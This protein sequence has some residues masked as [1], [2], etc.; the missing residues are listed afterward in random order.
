MHVTFSL[1]SCCGGS[2]TF[3]SLSIFLRRF[4]SYK[5]SKNIVSEMEFLGVELWDIIVKFST[6]HSRNYS[7]FESEVA[8]RTASPTTFHSPSSVRSQDGGNQLLL[9]DLGMMDGGQNSILGKF[10]QSPLFAFL[11]GRYN[12]VWDHMAQ[13]E[14]QEEI[15]SATKM[16]GS[17]YTAPPPP[18]SNSSTTANL[19][20]IQSITG[21]LPISINP[22]LCEV[23]SKSSTMI[24][25]NTEKKVMDESS[26]DIIFTTTYQVQ[27]VSFQSGGAFKP[28]LLNAL[29]KHSVIP[30]KWWMADLLLHIEE[31]SP[32]SSVSPLSVI[33]RL[34]KVK[35]MF[36]PATLVLCTSSPATADKIVG[37]VIHLEEHLDASTTT[38]AISSLAKMVCK[39]FQGVFVAGALLPSPTTGSN[40]SGVDRDTPLVDVASRATQYAN[41]E[42]Y[43]YIAQLQ[44][45]IKAG[46]SIKGA[47]ATASPSMQTPFAS[48]SASEADVTAAVSTGPN[49]ADIGLLYRDPEKALQNVDLQDA[50]EFTLQEF[51]NKMTEKF[52]KRV[53]K[54]GDPDYVY[55][56]RV[57]IKAEKASEW[58]DSDEE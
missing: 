36:D 31:S 34:C 9:H 8:R 2:C 49:K 55:D 48:A 16:V 20:A 47:G 40:S 45:I 4:G 14:M 35:M 15:E 5:F 54:P 25:T 10:V 26:G 30:K 43:K 33:P 13:D 1:L 56:K 12:H 28:V 57:E 6:K 3:L 39:S 58:D 32:S 23:V 53:V 18:S 46:G 11:C 21:M 41:T 17:F 24:V 42:L 7:R 27:P 51:K 52:S 38:S 29:L 37:H 19:D 44:K 22:L 50:D